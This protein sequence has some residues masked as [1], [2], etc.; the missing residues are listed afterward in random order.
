MHC[1]IGIFSRKE[2]SDEVR[3]TA[4]EGSGHL[5]GELNVIGD[6][7]CTEW[8]FH[9]ANVADRD[10]VGPFFITPPP[11]YS[12]PRLSPRREARGHWR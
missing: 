7:I 3:G 6:E 11:F 12:I 8:E 1:K 10:C 2:R 4:D 5:G 9:V